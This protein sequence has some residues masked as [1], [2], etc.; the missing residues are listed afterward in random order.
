MIR[1][2]MFDGFIGNGR[3]KN[4]NLIVFPRSNVIISR[5]VLSVAPQ[6]FIITERKAKPMLETFLNALK[7]NTFVI[8]LTIVLGLSWPS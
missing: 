7:V 5:R 3:E 2:C 6:Y 4:A 1:C 8:V